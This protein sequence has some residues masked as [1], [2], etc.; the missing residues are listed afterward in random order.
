METVF[1][2]PLRRTIQTA[3]LSFGPT[4]AR[5]EV[6]FILLPG[7]QEVG[8]MKSDTG[9]ADVP[10]DL[11]QILPDLF[12]EAELTF[13]LDRIDSSALTKGWNSKA[14]M[15]CLSCILMPTNTPCSKVTGPMRSQLYQ[16]VLQMSG[17]G[18]FSDQRQRSG[19]RHFSLSSLCLSAVDRSL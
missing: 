15:A 7:L 3:A 1:A 19:C 4:L 5:K 12:A 17:T 13:D 6:P 18:C 10:E 8:D 9:I 11:T 14:S 2:S 16:D